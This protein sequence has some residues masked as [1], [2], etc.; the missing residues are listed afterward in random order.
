M[1]ED[2]DYDPSVVCLICKSS[3]KTYIVLPSC[4]Q[5]HIYCFSCAQRSQ[6]TPR[7]EERYGMFG[8]YNNRNRNN[9]NAATITCVL[10]KSVSKLDPSGVS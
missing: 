5:P 1:E 8:R 3:P 7:D 6:Q 9:T 4:E 2:A 10:C